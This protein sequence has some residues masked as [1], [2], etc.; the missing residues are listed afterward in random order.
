MV[1]FNFI[2]QI[3]ISALILVCI[4]S[5]TW[6][7]SKR[8]K[9]VLKG[10]GTLPFD[11]IPARLWRVFEEFLLQKKVLQ[12]RFIPGLMHA[13]VFWGFIA[14]ALITIDH[15]SFYILLFS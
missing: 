3:L 14:F 8:F 15:F 2:E 9:L 10:E 6:E 12:Q 4:G 13:F 11:N 1:Y 7:L 5:F